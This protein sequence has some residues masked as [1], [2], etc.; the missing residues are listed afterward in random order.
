[1]CIKARHVTF[2]ESMF[3]DKVVS[4]D[5]KS[6]EHDELLI[7][8]SSDNLDSTTQPDPAQSST[9]ASETSLCQPDVV[10]MDQLLP[11]DT[12]NPRRQTMFSLQS[13]Q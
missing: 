4:N 2:M 10:E 5:D 9:E 13:V 7:L 6:K 12:V 3:L 11:D 8:D 1:K